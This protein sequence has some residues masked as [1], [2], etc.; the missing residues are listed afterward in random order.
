MTR[1]IARI[2]VL[3]TARRLLVRVPA[4]DLLCGLHVQ[5]EILHVVDWCPV[6]DSV[7]LTLDRL[8]E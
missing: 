5:P 8:Q 6:Q 7:P 3:I 4:G 2:L 1:W